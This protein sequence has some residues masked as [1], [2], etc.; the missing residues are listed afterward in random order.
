MVFSILLTTVLL[1]VVSGLLLNLF[2]CGFHCK[3][4]CLGTSIGFLKVWSSNPHL[5]PSFIPNII[6]FLFHHILF[7]KIDSLLL[8]QYHTLQHLIFVLNFFFFTYNQFAQFWIHYPTTVQVLPPSFQY[9][10]F[11]NC[12]LAY[13]LVLYRDKLKGLL[14]L[15]NSSKTSGFHRQRLNVRWVSY[16]A[17]M[18]FIDMLICMC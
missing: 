13:Y 10:L 8:L 3:T 15:V 4:K 12:F 18:F 11:L 17:S 1:H 14:V 16:L 2:H 7:Q 6:Q 5:F 9:W